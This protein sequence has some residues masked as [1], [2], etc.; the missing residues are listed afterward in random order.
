MRDLDRKIELFRLLFPRL[1]SFETNDWEENFLVEFTHDSTSI[2]G[3]T[4]T[5]IE[6]KMILTDAVVPSETSLRE[7]DEVRGHADA[8][9]FVKDCVRGGKPLSETMITACSSQSTQGMGRD[10]R[11][12]LS[13]GARFIYRCHRKG[14]VD[15]CGVCED[16]SISGWK[17]SDG[18]TDHEL[19]SDGK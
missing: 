19:S 4:L 8:W 14:G 6:T 12:C 9:Q 13:Y 15:S 17:W 11:F 1:S 2:E 10:E 5:L 18:T 7:L 3:N 16:P